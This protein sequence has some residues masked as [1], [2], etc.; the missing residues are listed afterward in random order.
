MGGLGILLSDE[1]R[2]L[3]AVGLNVVVFA[4][5]YRFARRRTTD[6]LQAVGDAFLLYYLVQYLA[7]CIPGFAGGLNLA[8]M[9]TT[10]VVL[11]GVLLFLAKRRPPREVV[12]LPRGDF[13]IVS[14]CAVF[15]VA[16]VGALIQHEAHLPVTSNDALTYHLP[17]AVEWLQSGRLGLYQ[18]WF[19]N[20]AN[21]YSPLAGSAFIAWLIAPTN[22]DVLARFVEAIPLLFI[23][24][25]MTNIC[26]ALG[27]RASVGA[28][29]ATA[30]VLS[31]PFV[32]Q[33]ILAKDDLFVVA[34]F[35]CVVLAASKE[36]LAE[37]F[38]PWRIAIALGLMLATKYTALFALPILVLLLDAPWRA[39]WHARYYGAATIL[40]LLLAGPW[41]ARN[42]VITGNP[43]YPTDVAIGG[44]TIFRGMFTVHRSA[45][46][47]TPRGVWDVF[48]LGYFSAPRGI[49]WLLIVAWGI[50]IVLN[51]RRVTHDPLR[52]AVLIGPPLAMLIFALLAPYGEM[53]FAYPAI[54]LL[55]ASIVLA[56]APLPW[57]LQSAI[58][59]ACAIMAGGT[60]FLPQM[61][62]QFVLIGFVAAIVGVGLIELWQRRWIPPILWPL[63]GAVALLALALIAYVYWRGYI[64]QYREFGTRI[65]WS[66][67][68]DDQAEVWRFVRQELP[69]GSKL[70]YGNTYLVYPLMG[71]NYDHAVVYAPT[72]KGLERFIEMPRIGETMSGEEIPTHIVRLLRQDPDREQWIDRLR[73]SG[74]EYLVVLTNDP[75]KPTEKIIPPEQQFADQDASRFERIFSNT[76]G[77]VY[78]IHWK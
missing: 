15:V 46:L 3:Y 53:R 58:A 63:S 40:V 32:S 41:Y 22:N 30:A 71:F 42:W 9:A 35:A 24:M 57:V 14:A 45:L 76:G 21:A 48:T 64:A 44:W 17:A 52:R 54:I 34:F 28:L 66:D 4:A 69:T 27:A 49:N 2:L 51:I 39:G 62:W 26:R 12:A 36:R 38:S 19:Y 6:R 10:A 29:V 50:G 65:T 47:A 70:A 43:L 31:R 8:T 77:M 7:V 73:K 67:R 33:V 61:A 60:A 56:L 78:R 11:C 55:F 5:G 18:A 13:L 74:A 16:Y 20:P 25:V 72:R 68:Y 23:F 75:A 59:A 37:R 1:L